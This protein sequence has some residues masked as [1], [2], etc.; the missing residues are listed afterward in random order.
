L[1]ER[2]AHR[3]RRPG[4]GS[5][6]SF[7]RGIELVQDQQRLAASFLEGHRGDGPR[8][9][10]IDFGAHHCLNSSGFPD[11][12]R[13]STFEGPKFYP[14][15]RTIGGV[16]LFDFE[17]FEPEDYGR[18]YPMSSW[19]YFVPYRRDWR[20]FVWIEIVRQ[21]VARNIISS[22]DLGAPPD[23]LYLRHVGPRGDADRTGLP[24]ALTSA[25]YDAGN[26]LLT[27]GSLV[28]S[29]DANGNLASD[30]PTSYSWNARDQLTALIGGTGASFQYDGTGRRRGKTI[31]AVTTNFLYDGL[32]FV[33]ELSGGG[34]VT[35]NLLTGLDVD[36]TFIRTNASASNT[37]LVDALGSTL[38]LADAFGTL[39]THY[40]FEPS[41]RQRPPARRVRM[42]RNSLAARPIPPACFSIG[43]DTRIRLCRGSRAKT[44]SDSRGA[45]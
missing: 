35:A 44:R 14:Y 27:W 1:L 7:L 21:L 17:G 22:Q 12:E 37:L 8:N 23:D 42:R 24:Q 5:V 30:G 38:E 32:N 45:I 16:S 9:M 34:A 31:N 4:A 26:P 3:I 6:E 18:K 41:E 39:Q 29:Y 19:S 20:T 15:V 25:T 11:N 28:F 40:T 33:Q 13:W 43:A 10:P 2:L 36:E